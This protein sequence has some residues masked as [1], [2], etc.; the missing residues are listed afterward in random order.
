MRKFLRNNLLIL[1]L[2]NSSNLF[3]YFFQ[4]VVGRALTPE[5]YGSFNALNSVAVVLSAPVAVLPLVF[6]RYTIQLAKIGINQVKDLLVKG[7]KWLT[8]IAFGLFIIEIAATPLIKEYL[9]LDSTIPIILMLAQMALALVLPVILGILQ[10]LQRFGT[11][12]F[13]VSSVSLFRFLSGLIFV[14]L[15]GLGVNGAVLSGTL[16]FA[17]AIGIGPLVP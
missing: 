1:V 2:L 17:A 4:L 7:L 3:S 5:E 15:V 9:H 10:G 8:L 13:A 16:G 6:S 14:L 12:G 11:F